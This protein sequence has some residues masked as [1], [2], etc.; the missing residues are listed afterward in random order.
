MLTCELCG[1][2]FKQIL[3]ED[4][5]ETD[6]ERKT[7]LAAKSNKRGPFCSLC[8]HLEMALRHAELR[9]LKS[10]VIPIRVAQSLMP[11]GR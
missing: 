9:G 1:R 6:E 7:L 2:K 11:D 8:R 10:V 3:D 4:D 5:D